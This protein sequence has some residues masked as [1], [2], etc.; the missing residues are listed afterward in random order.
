MGLDDQSR[1]HFDHPEARLSRITKAIKN[2]TG[3]LANPHFSQVLGKRPS[4]MA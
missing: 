4:F 1:S 3:R 2:H